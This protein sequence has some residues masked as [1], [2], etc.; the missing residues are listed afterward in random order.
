MSNIVR[1]E[2][3]PTSTFGHAIQLILWNDDTLT[4]CVES[5]HYVQ[6][7]ILSAEQ[8]R[9]FTKALQSMQTEL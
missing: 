7:V 3:I 5:K 2:E 6:A 8:A 1:Q 9:L 4:M